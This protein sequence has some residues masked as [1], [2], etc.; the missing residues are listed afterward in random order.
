MKT[1]LPVV[2]VVLLLGA[3]WCVVSSQEQEL[4]PVEI[5][6]L[7]DENWDA[8][9][10]RGK[11]ADAII[12][13]LVIRN[14]NLVAVIGRPISTRNVNVFVKSNA[15]TLIDLTTRENQSD[16]LSA[17]YPGQRDYAYREWMAS[18]SSGKSLPGDQVTVLR[19]PQS[20]TITVKSA[21]SEGKPA[22][23]TRYMLTADSR[24]LEVTSTFRNE[25][26]APLK[27]KLIDDLRYDTKNEDVLKGADGTASQFTI[28]DRFWHQA[29]AI[30]AP[31]RQ[32]L[33]NSDPRT[34]VLKMID[35]AMNDEIEIPA[36]GS[37]TQTRQITAAATLPE[38]VAALSSEPHVRTTLAIQSS[39][40]RR[41]P[42][43]RAEIRQADQ[44]LGTIVSNDRGELSTSLKPGA[45]VLKVLFNGAVVGENLPL[46]IEPAIEQSQAIRI[47][48]LEPGTVVARITDGDGRPMPCKVSFD[49]PEGMTAP[50]F[51]P[52][53]AEFG[54]RNLRYTPSG[55]FQQ[56]LAP[57]TYKARISRGPEYDS[58]VVELVVEAGKTVE[59]NARLPRV[60]DTTGWVSGDFHS[61][62]SPS[63]DNTTSQLGR[64]LNLTSEHIEFAPCTEHNR[65]SSY[66]EH[67]EKLKIRPFMATC[68]GM[69]MT[70]TPL[71]L[72]HQNA[73]PLHHHPHQQDGGGPTYDDSPEVQIER[74]A[75][76]DNRSE[77]LVQ[78]NHPD[79]GWLFYDRNG[80]GEPDE[81][82]TKGFAFMDVMEVHPLHTILDM[83]PT[84]VYNEKLYNNTVFNWLQLLN[85]GHKVYGVVNTDAHYNFHGSGGIRNWIQSSTDDP[86]RIDTLEM[87][88]ASEQG[89]LIM[90]NGPFLE[91][92]AQEPGTDGRVTCGQSLIAKSKS[93][94]L[95]IRVQCPNWTDI[96]RVFVL[97]NGRIVSGHDYTREKHPEVFANGVIKFDRKI[98]LTLDQDAH[99]IVVA[100]SEKTTI[101]PTAGPE[102]GKQQPTAI[103]NPIF[104]DVT[105]DG[106]QPN[107]DTLGQPLPVKQGGPVKK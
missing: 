90:S 12:G 92:W 78:Q 5:I 30:E 11:E 17:F 34:T 61:H 76:W 1:S 104:V 100:A 103:G 82:Y 59:L 18:D 62:A 16:Q 93:V 67:I 31:G 91:V 55:E 46:Q 9:A 44:L 39:T 71:P 33:T 70:G 107:R 58:A 45:Y 99:L 51:G 64:V 69:E 22:V 54:V 37:F 94:D 89:R 52:D 36:G 83:Q 81:G 50:H 43:T 101:G 8:T 10:P 42:F 20:A 65:I 57:G 14:R 97:A 98:L 73:F 32:L 38:A 15:G 96:D 21:A 86:A 40:G 2:V 72:N 87:V 79:V 75:L 95:S 88:H 6:R 74:L 66:D 7:T 29:Y 35:G 102:Y 48:D 41:L 49:V 25:T 80:D 23:D 24:S 77:K 85:Q 53:T 60:V 84:K 47:H 27:V 28:E 68:T 4:A 13:D 19:D 3:M 63:G 106:F 26:A 56:Q 105:G